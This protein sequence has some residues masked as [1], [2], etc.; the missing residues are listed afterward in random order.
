MKKR[1]QI[2]VFIVIGLLILLTYVALTFYG[3]ESELQKEV[4][5]PELI[6]VQQFVESCTRILG[7]EAV[8]LAGINGGYLTFPSWVDAAPYRVLQNSPNEQI[9]NPYWW[10]DGITAIPPLERIEQDIEEYIEEGLPNCLDNFTVFNNKFQI[11]DEGELGVQVTLGKEGRK[12]EDIQII[13][14]YPIEVQDKFNKTLAELQNYLVILPI[15]F[16]E[17]YELA[18][19]IMDRA[20]KDFFVEERIIDLINLDP[21]LPTTGFDVDC[22]KKI[23]QLPKVEDKLKKL[24]MV[25]LNH[26][27]LE[28]TKYDENAPLPYIP[29][30]LPD[31]RGKYT[32]EEID[33]FAFTPEQRE[34]LKFLEEEI[35]N[36]YKDSYY[37]YHY[38]WDVTDKKY[39]STSVNFQ[40]DPAWPMI[41][42]VSPNR[43][44]ILE[45]NAQKGQQILSAFCLKV[46]HFTYSMVFPIKV[47]ISDKRTD[48]NDPFTFS[49]VYMGKINKN[50]PDTTS[51]DFTTL[52]QRDTV[53][54]EDYC[55]DIV[56]A[57]TM[58]LQ[59]SDTETQSE[60]NNVNFTF[61]CGRYTC[62]IGRTRLDLDVANTPLLK[63]PLPQCTN[64][65]LRANKEGY[66][67]GEI[68]MQTEIIKTYDVPLQPIKELEI[69][70]KKYKLN[71]GQLQG[72]IALTDEE[73]ATVTIAY[74]EKQFE[75][76]AIHKKDDS[77]ELTL[78]AKSR[79]NYRVEIYLADEDNIKGGY[80]GNWTPDPTLLKLADKVT[81]NV[82]EQEFENDDDA[83]LFYAD[84]PEHS[85]K[86]PDFTLTR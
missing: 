49:F 46:W 38:V 82:I 14:T 21:D 75:S 66:Q 7:E 8:T 30:P 84:L 45:A 77:S 28:N 61:T 1:G 15:R 29:A 32:D 60:L 6:P 67:Q 40:Y 17:V 86:L 65:V 36:T 80:L 70:V 83:Y 31:W 9:R 18:A 3:T 5:T 39:P 64:A 35:Q 41:L 34:S 44:P 37:G 63:V 52:F 4:V 50:V 56:G 10:F 76:F 59:A 55:Q 43:G 74:P 20:K 11:F 53:T 24:M 19:E 68:F 73:Q 47:T 33:S 69:D 16:H 72:P 13:T 79:F 25:N 78:L 71:N 22:R 48:T 26:I 42:E 57:N 27:K 23:W 58:T 12:K 62:D 51:R 85:K 2:T 54:S 81:F